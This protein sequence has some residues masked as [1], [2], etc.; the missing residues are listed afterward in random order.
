MRYCPYFLFVYS[1]FKSLKHLPKILRPNRLKKTNWTVELESLLKTKIQKNPLQNKINPTAKKATLSFNWK[2]LFIFL[3]W[4][5]TYTHHINFHKYK[6]QRHFFHYS[7]RFFKVFLFHI[8][9]TLHI[10]LSSHLLQFASNTTFSI[11]WII[12]SIS[13]FPFSF[14]ASSKTEPVN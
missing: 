14:Q 2:T 5:M 3:T 13:F 4:K 10:N 1:C 7:W 9:K 8:N 6:F 11:L 12:S